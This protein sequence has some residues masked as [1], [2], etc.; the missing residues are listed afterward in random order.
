MGKFERRACAEKPR[1]DAVSAPP[2]SSPEIYYV[3]QLHYL[4]CWR[5]PPSL[6]YSVLTTYTSAR[7][8]GVFHGNGSV[9]YSSSSESK[10]A[11]NRNAPNEACSTGGGSKYC[12]CT[13]RRY[14]SPCGVE[15]AGV[16][17]E[18]TCWG[19]HGILKRP[20]DA[21]LVALSAASPEMADRRLEFVKPK[22]VGAS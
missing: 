7:W 11:S 17:I 9:S 8:E 18:A 10:P 1:R 12:C 6:L 19:K 22:P 21:C 15:L 5:P 14:I 16:F 20:K 4:C 13:G 2:C 3:L